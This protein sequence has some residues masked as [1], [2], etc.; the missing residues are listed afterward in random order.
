MCSVQLQGRG[1]CEA[2]VV[3]GAV[4]WVILW[5]RLAYTEGQVVSCFMSLLSKG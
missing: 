5:V 4:R 2:S 3:A 1:R